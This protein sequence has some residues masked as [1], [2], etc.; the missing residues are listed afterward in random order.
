MN[1]Q[2]KKKF[3]FLSDFDGTLSGKDFYQIIIDEYYKEKGSE[4][5]KAWKRDEYKDIDFLGII[6]KAINRN[7]EEILQDIHNIPFDEYAKSFI[8]RI[9]Q[10]GGDFAVLSAGT[11]YYIHRLFE[12]LNIK[13]IKIFSNEGF[14]KENGIHL[15]LDTESPFYSER[16]GID[17]G[18]V[19]ESLRKEYKA[20]YYAGDS[21]PDVIPAMN[22]D[23]AF[24]KGVLQQ[25]LKEKN[26]SFVPV[27][28]FKQI[29]SYLIENS[30]IK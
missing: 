24:A 13:D 2:D 15:R 28:N 6:Y 9:K 22:A 11:N 1:T 26:H 25:L 12:K 23:I 5:Y 7:E 19:L 29:E 30:I 8:E 20:V 18:K 3:I 10:N 27:E 16:Y 4:L 17:K 14:F 21:A